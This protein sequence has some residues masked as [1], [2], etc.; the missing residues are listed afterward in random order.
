MRRL[1][2]HALLCTVVA[3]L[4]AQTALAQ[5]GPAP[6]AAYPPSGYAPAATYPPAPEA[7]PWGQGVY[8]RP[9]YTANRGYPGGGYYPTAHLQESQPLP[10]PAAPMEPMEPMP[11]MNPPMTRQPAQPMA[12][13]PT[14]A[15]PMPGAAEPYHAGP[16]PAPSPHGV[17]GQPQPNMPAPTYYHQPACSGGVY[18]PTWQPQACPPPQTPIAA[19]CESG[20]WYSRSSALI[21]GRERGNRLWVSYENNNN[22]NQLMHTNDAHVD[23]NGGG[24]V[25]LGRQ[26]AC[27]P[28]AIEVAYWQ[29]ATLEGS[30][31]VTHANLVSTPLD[32]TDVDFGLA[33]AD[34]Y[35]DSAAEH[36]LRR[37]N[38]FLNIE[39]NLVNRDL[40]GSRC[41]SA[42]S[43]RSGACGYGSC[44]DVG[45]CPPPRYVLRGLAGF[46]YFRFEE[47]IVFSSLDD[48][49]SWGGAG[50]A[51]EAHLEDHVVNSL[52]GFQFGSY[53]AWNAT[54]RFALTCA[55]R[56]G[57]FNNRVNHRFELYRG[58][59]V[60]ATPDPASGIGGGYPI[61]TSEDVFSVLC[62]LDVG[63]KY[64]VYRNWSLVGGYRLV[65]LSNI[66]LADEQ[67]PPYLADI[68][69]I[70][71]IDTSNSLLLHG[72]Y[73]GVGC[74]W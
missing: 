19:C 31:S 2:W 32:L 48:G 45:C 21:L 62:Q 54:D 40:L 12:P 27:S 46:R 68:P 1:G 56:I 18:Q 3:T 7:N 34:T 36:R 25:I 74:N 49:G 53:M 58:D 38:D 8:Q 66:A 71:N 14:P 65:A 61:D 41:G 28:W 15:P 67:I 44:C 17:W 52:L 11:P 70:A 26:F 13:R 23:W 55:P 16:N 73:F 37:D 33:D 69:E 50:G 5:W 39:I 24:E 64:C 20:I 42:A 6:P 57:L 72:A 51:N 22:P 4:L 10:A 9:P 35:F 29:L 47:S 59:G 63:V 43:M 60:H 30:S